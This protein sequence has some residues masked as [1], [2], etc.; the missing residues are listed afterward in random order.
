MDFK[1]FIALTTELLRD[2]L[3]SDGF[4]VMGEGLLCRRQG[5]EINVISIQLHSSGTKCCVNL[6]VHYNFIPLV[7]TDALAQ[8]SQIEESACE[9]RIR[10]TPT[11]EEV[12]HWWCFSK[13]SMNE[14]VDLIIV[15]Q[16]DLF[17]LYALP[18][19][20]LLKP[21]DLAEKLPAILA[22]LTRVRAC[23][24]LARI[25]EHAGDRERATAFANLGIK[26]AGQAVGPKKAFKDMLRR[27]GNVAS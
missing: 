20:K 21:E 16:P 26:V 11:D 6:G 1:E 19:I 5:E 27:I 8:G 7:G 22:P 25:N 12:D 2:R 18:R 24:L 3:S 17:C 9:I 15:K 10:L 14:M 23:L 4:Y 13:Q